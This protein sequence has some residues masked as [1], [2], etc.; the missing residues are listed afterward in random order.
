M[1]LAEILAKIEE[2]K[3]RYAAIVD[4]VATE[5]RAR[6][7]EEVDGLAAIKT[8][9]AALEVRRK[10]AQNVADAA[11]AV[12]ARNAAAARA[13]AQGQGAAPQTSNEFYRAI[14]KSTS[15]VGTKEVVADVVR[16]YESQ[17]PLFAAHQNK[18][19]RLTGE[20]YTYPK[21]TAGTGGYAKTEGN[22]GTADGGGTT[23]TMIDATFVT[24]SSQ[25]ITVSQEMLD[26]AGF[27]ISGEIAAVGLAKST[28]AFDAAAA[29]ALLTYDASPTETAAT[30]WALSDLI[31]AY[32]E[33]PTRNRTGVK[34]IMP[35]AT[36]PA[37]LNLLTAD[38]APKAAAIGLSAENIIV[39]DNITATQVVVCN[40]TFALAI[41]MKSQVRVFVDEVSAGRTYEVQPRLAVGLRD[42]TAVSGRILKAA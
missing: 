21:V 16:V 20:K 36:V 7:K 37:I 30:S 28:A 26:D 8:E 24:Y 42:T 11:A 2:A 25:T 23:I 22:A 40:P 1:T 34:F 14:T 17:S 5:N 12:E 13:S 35:S 29:T 4:K 39:D 15:T 32:Y 33:I 27:D 3:G 19:M 31:A 10:D 41:G 6:V 9:I 18:Q 38:N